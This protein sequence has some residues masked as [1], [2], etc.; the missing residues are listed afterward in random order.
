MELPAD[1]YLRE[2]CSLQNDPAIAAALDWIEQQTNIHTNYPRM[3]SGKVQGSLLN[4]LVRLSGARKALEI[5]TFTGYSAVCIALA[6]PEDGHLDAFEINDELQDLI[7]EGCRRAGVDSKI[8]LHI[9]DAKEAL[10][11]LTGNRLAS[12]A[13]SESSDGCQS[14]A[15]RSKASGS[16][17]ALEVGSSASGDC[18]ASGFLQESTECEARGAASAGMYDFAFIDANKREYMQY[19]ELVL[20]VLR[21]GG[22]I[23][24]DDVLWDGK[25]YA[26]SGHIC[27]AQ[28]QSLIRFNDFVATDKRVES[29]IL[30]LRDGLTIVRKK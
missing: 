17:L 5:G 29:V 1:K 23:V 16:C 21:P 15:A 3:L 12:A 9:G 13:R 24:V 18:A 27:D 19:Y 4:M 6:L 25:V 30:P 8:A 2:H 10:K 7:L 28:T 22:L 26:E 14:S 20:D 11:G